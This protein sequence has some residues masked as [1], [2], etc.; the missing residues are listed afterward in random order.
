M[1]APAAARVVNLGPYQ[2]GW[3]LCFLCGANGWP[4]IGAM[5]GLLLAAVHLAIVER[6]G[7]RQPSSS[8]GAR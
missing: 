8:P 5:A 1:T 7:P 2:T 6:R 4:W 3:F